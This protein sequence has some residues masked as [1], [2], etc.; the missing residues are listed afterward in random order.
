MGQQQH[1]RFPK[2]NENQANGMLGLIRKDI[3][4]P[5]LVTSLSSSK[6]FMALTYDYSRFTSVYFMK[7]KDED[8]LTF[9]IFKHMIKKFIEKLIKYITTNHGKGIYVTFFYHLPS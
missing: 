5:L 3:C 8:L 9:K 1:E 7:K 4:G 6:Y 2:K